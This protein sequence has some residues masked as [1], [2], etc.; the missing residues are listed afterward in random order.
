MGGER[1]KV[2]LSVELCEKVA[3]AGRREVLF[4]SANWDAIPVEGSGA[5]MQF[6]VEENGESAAVS[7][8]EFHVYWD[9]TGVVNIG[10]RIENLGDEFEDVMRCAMR[11]G[12]AHHVVWKKEWDES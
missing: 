6:G 11:E 12:Y 7:A 8:N 3:F 10:M 9:T 2:I 1:M 5:V 4:K